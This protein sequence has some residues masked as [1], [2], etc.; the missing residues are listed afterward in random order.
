MFECSGGGSEVS[1][2][3]Y[4]DD[5]IELSRLELFRTHQFLSSLNKMAYD[6]VDTVNL[7][8]KSRQLRL[9]PF[10]QK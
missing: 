5:N 2:A 1:K 7:D 4:E 6:H 8:E 10:I 9:D 3:P